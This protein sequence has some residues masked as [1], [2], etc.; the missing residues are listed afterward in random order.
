MAHAFGGNGFDDLVFDDINELLVD[1]VLSEDE[2][3]HFSSENADSINNSDS[4][5]SVKLITNLIPKGLAN[6]LEYHFAN[7]IVH[8]QMNTQE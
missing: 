1:Q 5:E 3:L 8:F 7:R 4:E 6:K 2:I